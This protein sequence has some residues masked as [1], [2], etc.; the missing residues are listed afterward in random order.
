MPQRT[1]KNILKRERNHFNDAAAIVGSL[2]E[3]D[4]NAPCYVRWAPRGLH[5]QQWE[6]VS[7]AAE[8][9]CEG[10]VCV[11]TGGT[12]V[13]K[14]TVALM[15]AL[16]ARRLCFLVCPSMTPQETRGVMEAI[17]PRDVLVVDD[18]DADPRWGD[19]MCAAHRAV[20]VTQTRAVFASPRRAYTVAPLRPLPAEFLYDLLAE[21]TDMSEPQFNR[22]RERTNGDFRR[23]CLEVGRSTAAGSVSREERRQQALRGLRAVPEMAVDALDRRRP[24]D[25]RINN[26][27]TDVFFYCTRARLP[28]DM[29]DAARW[30]DAVSAVSLGASAE[31][32]CVFAPQTKLVAAGRGGARC[33]VDYAGEP[34]A[35]VVGL[36]VGCGSRNSS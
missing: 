33:F 7:A 24:I 1:L 3:R 36:G 9:L 31:M 15:V 5:P 34:G 35:G 11:I 14:T 21:H 19:R 8:G 12:G 17:G 25:Y 26:M 13:G 28:V 29:A 27:D 6:D 23:L 16:K 22:A 32:L 2:R 20:V 4:P 10:R 18:Y 30:A